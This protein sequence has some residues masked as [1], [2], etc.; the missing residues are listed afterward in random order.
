MISAAVPTH[1]ELR[2][3]LINASDFQTMQFLSRRQHSVMKERLQMAVEAIVV[4]VHI[5]SY[6]LVSNREPKNL[7]RGT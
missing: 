5:I 7:F 3:N 6:R 4:N 2:S 1:D